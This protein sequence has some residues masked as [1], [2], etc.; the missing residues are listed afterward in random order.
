M[1]NHLV[2]YDLVNKKPEA[3][4]QTLWDELK[5]LGAHRTQ[6]SSWLVSANNTPK[7]LVEHFQRFVHADDRIMVTRLHGPEHYYVNAIGGTNKWFERN[8][9]A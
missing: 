8:V 9:T 2:I 6:Y 5:R 7:E 1:A 4:Y 3:E